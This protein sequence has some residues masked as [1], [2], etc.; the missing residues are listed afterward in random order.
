MKISIITVTFNSEET[1]K[2]SIESILNQ[3]YTDIEYLIIDGGSKDG[4]IDMIKYYEPKFQGRLFYITE[5]DN[6]IYD[7]MNKGISMATGEVVG[8]L[9]SDD[10]L[11]SPD[12]LSKQMSCFVEGVDAVYGDVKYVYRENT[13]KLV[14][15]YS[16]AK[17]KRWKMRLGYM[18]AHPTFYCRKEVYQRYGAFK[19]HYKVATDFECLFRLIY[20]HQIKA[21]YNPM[22]IVTMRIGGVSSN[23]L[24]SCQQIMKDHLKTFREN[25]VYNNIFILSLRYFSKIMD[26]VEGKLKSFY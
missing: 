10:F 9:N 22:E 13:S 20:I 26:L 8:F 12:V 5:P 3:T 14:R 25:G 6:G 7:A 11:S 19:L 16:S 24:I 15:Y 17:F 1:L 18:P 21:I 4:T 23:G 2:D